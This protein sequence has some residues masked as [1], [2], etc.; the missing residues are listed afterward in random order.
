MTLS[1][2]IWA[3]A[4]AVALLVVVGILMGSFQEL[5]R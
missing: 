1:K 2:W 5:G 3:V 4:M